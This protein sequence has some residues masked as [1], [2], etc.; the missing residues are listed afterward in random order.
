MRPE[1]PKTLHIFSR[2]NAPSYMGSTHT[3]FSYELIETEQKINQ[4]TLGRE[5]YYGA[6]FPVGILVTAL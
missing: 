2:N 1:C 6:T 4:K 3:A 5:C